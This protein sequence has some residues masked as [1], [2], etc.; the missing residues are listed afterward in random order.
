MC[1]L[2]LKLF[3]KPMVDFL[4]VIIE[5]YR[6]LLQLKISSEILRGAAKNTT[7]PKCDFSVMP[8]DYCA[9]LYIRLKHFCLQ[10]QC[11]L[12]EVN[13]RIENWRKRKV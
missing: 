5:N 7:L 10:P 4:L 13:W 2:R 3:G 6:Q 8:A 1:T 12:I 11:F 9:K